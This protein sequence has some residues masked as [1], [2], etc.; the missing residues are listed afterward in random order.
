MKIEILSTGQIL[1]VEPE[2]ALELMLNTPVEVLQEGFDKKVNV[3]SSGNRV[4][5][6]VCSDAI[7]IID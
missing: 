1:D 5:Q 2:I 3:D 4:I 7:G 6:L